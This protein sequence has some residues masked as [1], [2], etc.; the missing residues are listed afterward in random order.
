MLGDAELILGLTAEG[1]ANEGK[2]VIKPEH[3]ESIDT[4]PVR[5]L[6]EDILEGGRD[7]FETRR[8]KYGF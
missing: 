1:E 2:A 4:Q 7:A 8:L 5:D 6:L 3:M